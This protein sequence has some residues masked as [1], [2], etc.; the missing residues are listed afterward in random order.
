MIRQI[1]LV[2]IAAGVPRRDR[3]RRR[4]CHR[5]GG[6]VLAAR[7]SGLGLFHLAEG[8]ARRLQGRQDRDARALPLPHRER[9][10][11]PLQ[12]ARARLS[13]L[14]GAQLDPDRDQL[15]RDLQEGRASGSSTPT[16]R[17]PDRGTSDIRGALGRCALHRCRRCRGA[18]AAPKCFGAAA[19]DAAAASAR[20]RGCRLVVRPSPDEAAI[21]PNLACTRAQLTEVLDECAYGVP[22]EDA[23]ETVAMIGD[24]HAAHWR[25]ALAVVAKRKRW[26]VLEIGRPHCPLSLA[27]PD[28]GEPVSSDCEAWNRQVVSWLADHPSVRTVF[29]SANAQAPIVVPDGHTEYATRVDGYV[30]AWQGLPASVQRIVVIRDN[31]TDRTRTHDCVRRAMTQAQAGGPRVRGRAA[32]RP[33]SGRGRH[34]REAAA[35]TRSP[36][37]RPHAL[38]LQPPPLPARGGRRA[39]AQG[40]RPSDTGLRP[41]ARAVPAAPHRRFADLSGLVNTQRPQ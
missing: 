36:R 30:R 13:L 5:C 41:H 22:A 20:T 17:T 24:S 29:V 3:R 35:G 32:G 11:G 6:H 9:P 40:R 8:Q 14:R 21:T 38:L 33:A 27:T 1:R 34:G 4:S 7:L 19:R 37:R 31:P 18:A 23:R 15:A 12:A 25:A 2:L 16:S 28:S 26:R 39:R 10:Q